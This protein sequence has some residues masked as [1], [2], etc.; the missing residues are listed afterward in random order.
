M[1]M[2]IRLFTII[3]LFCLPFVASAQQPVFKAFSD[4]RQVL[5][6]SYFEVSFT[7]ENGEGVNFKAPNFRNFKVVSGPSQSVSTTIVNGKMSREISFIYG[8]LPKA[9]GRLTIGPASITVDGKV[10]KTKPFTVEVLAAAKNPVQEDKAVFVKAEPA[11]TEIWE[12]QQLPLLYKLYFSNTQIANISI[13]DE[14]EYNAFY[15]QNIRNTDLRNIREIIDGVQYESRIIKKMVLFPQRTGSFT[16]DPFVLQLSIVKGQSGFFRRNVVYETESSAPV[17][18][19][20][21]PLPQDAP[22]NFNG[23]VGRFQMRAQLDK[24]VLTTDDAA[25]LRMTITGTGDIKRIHAPELEL[26]E[27]F[28]VYDPN[29]VRENSIMGSDGLMINEKTFEYLFVPNKPGD[30]EIMPSFCYFDVDSAKYVTL[31]DKTYNL[32]VTQGKNIKRNITIPEIKQEVKDI[33]PIHGNAMLEKDK[34][35]FLGSLFFWIL[36]TVPFL[37]FIGAFTLKRI[38]DKNANIDPLDI[39][40]KRARKLALKRL[41]EAGKLKE[42]GKTGAF[43]DEISRAMFGYV[44]DKLQIPFSELTKDNLHNRLSSLEVGETLIDD[45]MKVIK[46]CEIALY[47]GMDNSEAMDETFDNSLHILS[48]MEEKL[49]I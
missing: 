42:A 49:I 39:K 37:A 9:T 31:A 29:L 33:L 5:K 36:F 8:L 40:R 41:E 15:A 30:Y 3:A 35:P 21:K 26:P 24:P 10:L 14:S 43:Y 16:I 12:G 4:A 34:K 18:L 28:E 48:E 22:D 13:L 1:N 27:G 17:D 32:Q 19:L 46:N 7:L 44:C 11:E 47:A 25:T 23:C 20:I 6:D 2:R 45:F 38:E